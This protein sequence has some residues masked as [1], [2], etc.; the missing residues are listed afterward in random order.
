MSS[1]VGIAPIIDCTV[2]LPIMS[3]RRLPI[4]SPTLPKTVWNK[5]PVDSANFSMLVLSFPKSSLFNAFCPLSL[6]LSQTPLNFATN[7]SGLKPF[8][9]ASPI[10]LTNF[11]IFSNAF[12]SLPPSLSQAYY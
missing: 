6:I 11:F 3:D 1:A 8:K 12:C 4:N 10:L 7:L 9:N 5:L 2:S